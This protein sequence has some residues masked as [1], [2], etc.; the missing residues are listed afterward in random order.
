MHE[1]YNM[2]VKNEYIKT[3]TI[4]LD[5]G[6]CNRGEPPSEITNDGIKFVLANEDENVVE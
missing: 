6:D 3:I 2:Y 4:E 1:D 5:P